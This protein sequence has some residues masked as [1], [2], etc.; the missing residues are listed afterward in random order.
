MTTTTVAAITA[1]ALLAS[2]QCLATMIVMFTWIAVTTERV[3]V[4]EAEAEAAAAAAA[5][6]AVVVAVAAAAVAVEVQMMAN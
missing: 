4:A 1:L 6:A 5:A 2:W 3:I